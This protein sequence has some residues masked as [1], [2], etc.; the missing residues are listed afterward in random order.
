MPL[1]YHTAQS[2]VNS[3]RQAAITQSATQ[4]ASIMSN[5]PPLHSP[6]RIPIYFLGIGKLNFM[7]NTKHLAT[8]AVLRWFSNRA[9]EHDEGQIQG[10]GRL[11]CPLAR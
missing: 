6:P 11:L 2:Y 3:I 9:R 7:E 8:L 10:R 1:V 4:P 5:S